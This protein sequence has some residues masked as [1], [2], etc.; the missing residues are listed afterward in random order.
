MKK[1][2]LHLFLILI[3]GI[4]S[5]AQSGII[6]KSVDYFNYSG[7]TLNYLEFPEISQQL[8]KT[9]DSLSRK[10]LQIPITASPDFKVNKRLYQD[11]SLSEHVN[12]A[13]GNY[14]TNEKIKAAEKQQ[15]L[16]SNAS[17]NAK[18]EFSL[19][20]AEL[21][22]NSIRQ[23]PELDSL[24]IQQ[25]LQKQNLALIQMI[26]KL[27]A[28]TG[29]LLIDKQVCM[30]LSKNK[31]PVILGFN[32]PEYLITPK[33]FGKL[34]EAGL[35]VLLD[36]NNETEILQM[37]SIPAIVNDNFIQP[38]IQH[39][40]RLNFSNQKGIIQYLWKGAVQY[41]RYQEPLYENIVLR[42][43]KTTAIPKSL[44]AQINADNI[45]EPLF[46]REESRDI[47]ADKN[48]LLQCV[49]NVERDPYGKGTPFNKKTG[50]PFNFLSGISHVFLQDNDTIAQF[51]IKANF[52]DGKKKTYLNQLYIAADSS[53]VTLEKTVRENVQHYDFELEGIFKGQTFKIAYSGLRGS[54]ES[55]REIYL[56]EKMV[57]VVEG[58]DAP[59]LLVVLDKE[60]DVITL[61]QLLLLSFSN[62]F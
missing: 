61:N 43:K 23:F 58:K 5:Q 34:L 25:L 42:G 16:N 20:I 11:N 6:F 7:R 24:F 10:F 18:T 62:L 60:L 28:A 53:I 46:L 3:T 55:I 54:P 2:I 57:A 17:Q 21:P 37:N 22:L 1:K 8:T 26:A 13:I 45:W 30:V 39:Q 38:F 44:I 41:L 52:L 33:S 47:L 15:L 19:E 50:L 31:Q 4:S 35:S 32:H 40:P 51:K 12:L 27:K 14:A 48:Y 9:L 29:E 56:K 49:V 36:K 59:E